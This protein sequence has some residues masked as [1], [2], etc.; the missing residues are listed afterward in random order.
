MRALLAKQGQRDSLGYFALRRDKSVVWSAE[1][2]GLQSR[3][4]VVSGVM[5]ASGDPLGDPEAWPGAIAAFL[6]EAD[7]HAWVPA[8]IGL[9]RGRRHGVTR[10]PACPRSSSATRRSSRSRSS[11]SR[12]GRCATSGRRSSRVERAG[13][14]RRSSP[15]RATSTGERGRAAAAAGRRLARQRDRARLLDGARPVR[16]PRADCVAAMAFSGRRRRR[17]GD[18]VL[19][20]VLH[21]VPWGRDG[22]SLDLMLR[23]RD[24]DT[25]L[26]EYLIVAALRAAPR[27]RHHAGCR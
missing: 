27:A 5:L 25:G 14:S 23:D 16:R 24:A 12:A 19:R 15:G 2:Q 18:P 7:R 10:G 22:L 6:A 1:R 3:Y 21:F 4:R 20:A 8:V 11:P 26:N 9:Q 17:T 13:Y